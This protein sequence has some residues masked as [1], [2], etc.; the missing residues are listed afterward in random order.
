MATAIDAG[1]TRVPVTFSWRALEPESETYEDRSLAIAALMIPAMGVSIDLA[2]TPMSGSSQAMP[3]DLMGR[4]FDDPKVVTGPDGKVDKFEIDPF[5]KHCMVNGLDEIGLTL[6]DERLPKR[7]RS[8]P[9][10]SSGAL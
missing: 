3:R 8:K 5:R 10:G 4:A 2:I 9:G 1:V 6:M 7:V